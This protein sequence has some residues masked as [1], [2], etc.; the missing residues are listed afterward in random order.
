MGKS[1]VPLT[2]G[3]LCGTIRFQSDEAPVQGYYCHC[4]MCQRSY[5]GFFSATLRVPGRSF[6]FTKGEPKSYRSSRFATRS[7]CADCGSPMPFQFDASQDVWIKIG[8]LNHPEDWPMTDGAA[9][10]PSQH[11]FVGSK[12][13]WEQLGDHLP[14]MQEYDNELSKFLSAT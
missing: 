3:C 12:I 9:W 4:T 5:G 6:K 2:G 8:T 11:T 13:A 14:Q 7:F 1:H 10:G